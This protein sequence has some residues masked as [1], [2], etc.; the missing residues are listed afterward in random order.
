M[1]IEYIWSIEETSNK[2]ETSIFNVTL[3]RSPKSLGLV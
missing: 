1:S 2:D 3:M